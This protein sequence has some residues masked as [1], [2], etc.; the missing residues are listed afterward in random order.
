[1][2]RPPRER[3][4]NVIDASMLTRAWGLLGGISAVLVMGVFLLTLQQGGWRLGDD[5]SVGPLNHVWQQATTMSFLGIV[6]CQVGT[7]VAARTQHASL[8]QVGVLSNRLLLWGIAYEIVFA[9]A[10]VTLPP[11]Q[12]VFG[13][14]T[15]EAWQVL[16]ILPFPVLVWGA[17]ELWRWNARRH[18]PSGGRRRQRAS[19]EN[20][21]GSSS[22]VSAVGP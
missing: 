2:A 18:G 12:A 17:D 3:T 20:I 8:R 22:G 6:A 21:A 5:V 7:A 1:M 13:T 9:A 15:P 16:V 4:Q 14:A 10:L 11:L 19:A